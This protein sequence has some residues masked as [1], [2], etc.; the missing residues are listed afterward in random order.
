MVEIFAVV[1]ML[2]MFIIWSSNDF[3]NVF[4]KAS[5]LVISLWLAID[6]AY[7]MGYV[8]KTETVQ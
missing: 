8:I 6:T 2:F 7:E 1:L 3:F 5:F 4:L